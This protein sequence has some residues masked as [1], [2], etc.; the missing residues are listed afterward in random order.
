MS[1]SCQS[2]DIR[3]EAYKSWLFLAKLF[4]G[5]NS[6][7]THPKRLELII[8]PIRSTLSQDL[9]SRVRRSAM[10][11]WTQI[12]QIL[13]RDNGLER[14]NTFDVAFTSVCGI[15]LKDKDSRVRSEALKT[16]KE[17]LEVKP[18]SNVD[19]SV[20]S[21]A[22]EAS[23]GFNL[24]AMHIETL[25]DFL[26]HVTLDQNDEVK[27][28]AAQGWVAILNRI[29]F[30]VEIQN[31]EAA[32]TVMQQLCSTLL[33]KVVRS[34]E[35]KDFSDFSAF[36]S[37]HRVVDACSR[38]GCNVLA[39]KSILVQLDFASVITDVLDKETFQGAQMN[40]IAYL[41]VIVAIF[42]TPDVE[43]QLGP[44][45]QKMCQHLAT[46]AKSL[47]SLF[48]TIEAL[49][50][51]NFESSHPRDLKTR[52]E[53]GLVFCWIKATD[54]YLEYLQEFSVRAL[55]S[56]TKTKSQLPNV[57]YMLARMVTLVRSKD[58]D[59][60][61]FDGHSVP[62]LLRSRWLDYFVN[63]KRVCMMRHGTKLAAAEKIAQELIKALDCSEKGLPLDFLSFILQNLT[64]SDSFEVVQHT[65]KLQSSRFPPQETMLAPISTVCTKIVSCWFNAIGSD[66]LN[67]PLF[68]SC[69]RSYVPLVDR[70]N[71]T[72]SFV[73]LVIQAKSS[74]LQCLRCCDRHDSTSKLYQLHHHGPAGIADE[75]ELVWGKLMQALA[76]CYPWG[77]SADELLSTVCDLFVSAMEGTNVQ[78]KNKALDTWNE[79]FGKSKGLLKID[80]TLMK[81][82]V[83][84]SKRVKVAFPGNQ[85]LDAEDANLETGSDERNASPVTAEATLTQSV[86]FSP[87]RQ[88]AARGSLLAQQGSRN[89]TPV[90]NSAEKKR[91]TPASEAM[92]AAPED[93]GKDFIQIAHAKRKLVLTEHQREVRS[94]QREAA[95]VVL[96]YSGLED[97]ESRWGNSVEE[98]MLI[99]SDSRTQWSEA[100][101]QMATEE[102]RGSDKRGRVRE[103]EEQETQDSSPSALAG[104]PTPETV[105]AAKRGRHAEKLQDAQPTNFMPLLSEL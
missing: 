66:R 45:L 2:P 7:L 17:L 47:R 28:L 5:M 67:L 30:H 44:T 63:M 84:L 60:V 8:A 90:R 53:R 95:G 1:F 101:R 74:I 14:N 26:F 100:S 96:N 41:C 27:E 33:Q 48:E 81:V 57:A 73:N 40:V 86:S 37:V 94:Q 59:E 16:I 70:L 105:N 69:L 99:R 39:M 65:N 50:Q 88:V 54:S 18:N 20:T 19:S 75:V 51:W 10:G 9:S 104:H 91:S 22:N 12:V 34:F 98:A 4:S 35:Q 31:S 36:Q 83:K 13:N 58:I 85:P 23:L 97:A 11:V 93:R 68:K 64:E 15:A 49:R 62:E 29:S 103:R 52:L 43:S 21:M 89:S 87:A 79:T 38:Q 77:S 71:S 82:L 78:L 80:E 76:R 6:T 56:P 72:E 61:S 42:A 25:S 32:T 46:E 92:A 55:A 3:Q 24:I 102:T